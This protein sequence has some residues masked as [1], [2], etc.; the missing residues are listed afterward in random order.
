MYALREDMVDIC[1]GLTGTVEF[2]VFLEI[3]VA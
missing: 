1:D 2:K 3:G